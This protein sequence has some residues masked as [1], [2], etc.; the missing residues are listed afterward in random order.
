MLFKYFVA[1]FLCCVMVNLLWTTSSSSMMIQTSQVHW[2]ITHLILMIWLF[3]FSWSQV[4]QLLQLSPLFFHVRLARLHQQ[5]RS[6]CFKRGLPSQVEL[7]RQRPD[8]QILFH[9][10]VYYETLVTT[11][12]QLGVMNDIVEFDALKR[13][14]QK[15]TL[16]GLI[17]TA[18]LLCAGTF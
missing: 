8:V 1:L 10:F 7:G 18:S 12:K 5:L 13:E 3:C 14:K 9:R 2:T 16:Y 4:C 17:E 6:Q 11:L 15:Q